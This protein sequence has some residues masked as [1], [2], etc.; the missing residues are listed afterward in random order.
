MKRVIQILTVAFGLSMLTAY[1]VYSQLQQNPRPAVR[2][3]EIRVTG[4]GVKASQAERGAPAM[5]APGSKSAPVIAS[6]AV[7]AMVAPGSK[8]AAVL[9]PPTVPAMIAPGSKSKLI[10]HPESAPFQLGP[11]R[12]PQTPVGRVIPPTAQVLPESTK[13]APRAG[14]VKSLADPSVQQQQSNPPRASSR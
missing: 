7:P 11:E 13:P 1:V 6:R 5:I 2:T 10:L 4:P 14:A 3:G 8:S 12:E 9:T